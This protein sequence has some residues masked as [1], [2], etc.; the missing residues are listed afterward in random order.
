[1]VLTVRVAAL[2]LM[3]L[4]APASAQLTNEQ[5]QQVGFI[6]AENLLA[7][8]REQCLRGNN[9]TPGKK[10]AARIRSQQTLYAYLEAARSGGTF[11][12][13]QY[14]SRKSDFQN[15]TDADGHR[16]DIKAI[17]DPLAPAAARTLPEPKGFERAH[18]YRTAQGL[19]I[20]RSA[21][22]GSPLGGYAAGFR[23]ERG[24]WLLTD[25]AMVEAD[26]E[27]PRPYCNTPGDIGERVS[28][29]P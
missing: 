10:R 8:E 4:P 5:W 23:R 14:F 29:L 18:D 27:P 26:A 12:A 24:R 7:R 28:T 13:A 1:M 6:V 2:C 17:S 21:A 16:R 22:D 19:W 3:A 11:D 9:L 25:L 20:L 15:W